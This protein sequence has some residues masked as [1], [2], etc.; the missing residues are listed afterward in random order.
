MLKTVGNVI[1]GSGVL[2]VRGELAGDVW[3]SGGSSVLG[4]ARPN[5][6]FGGAFGDGSC[7]MGGVGSCLRI[8][9]A[10]N[11]VSGAM[12]GDGGPLS[13]SFAPGELLDELTTFLGVE[14]SPADEESVRGDSGVDSECTEIERDGCDGCSGEELR[15]PGTLEDIASSERRGLT[16][17]PR[18]LPAKLT[19]FLSREGLAVGSSKLF[20]EEF[21]IDW[22]LP[23]DSTLL[24]TLSCCLDDLLLV[25]SG[26]SDMP[27]SRDKFSLVLTLARFTAFECGLH[28]SPSASSLSTVFLGLA[29]CTEWAR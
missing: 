17:I 5:G 25:G 2:C 18:V 8:G 12:I 26:N 29:V 24:L 9:S 20:P 7:R 19:P 27:R 21:G 23:G 13:R 3:R 15:S 11:G 28:A 16:S 4:A 22:S 6:A 10:V 1:G 14:A